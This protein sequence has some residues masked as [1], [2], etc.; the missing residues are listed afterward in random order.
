MRLPLFVVAFACIMSAQVRPVDTGAALVNPGMGWVHHHLDND[1]E[2]YGS[3]LAPEDTLDDFP[4]LSTIYLRLAWS[5][6]E[7]EEGRFR[8]SIV[9]APMQKW[10]AKG[11]RVALRFSCSETSY[12]YATPRW[13][14]QAGAKGYRFVPGKGVDPSG[15][16]WEPDFDDPVFLA[17]LDNFL[18]AAA[19]RYDGD[20]NVAFIDVASFGVW[21]EGHTSWST[22]RNYSAETV[23]RHLDLHAKHFKKTLLLANDDFA[24]HGRGPASI[25]HARKLGMGLRDD[26]ILVQRPPNSYYSAGMAQSFWRDVPVILE[27]EHYG[28]SKKIDAWGDGSLYLKAIEEYHA[29]Y[30]SIHWWPREFLAE[31]LPLIDKINLRLGYRLQVVEADWP[32]EVTRGKDALATWTWRNAGVA[33]VYQGA[34]PSLTLKTAAGGIVAVLVQ[35]DFNFRDLPTGGMTKAAQAPIRIPADVKPGT[36]RVFVS[37]GSRTGTPQIE[38]PHHHGDGQRRYELGTITVR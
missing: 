16:L 5:F 35:E 2:H 34:F 11:K 37:V 30:A 1:I 17:K 15:K 38:L 29:S 18:R 3:K 19:A 8:W 9:D 21:G 24:N 20:P 7:P 13:V 33:P 28:N 26:S 25:E 36:Y 10:V 4:G 22:K 6:I 14:E 23:I 12:E 32:K 31:M 27:S